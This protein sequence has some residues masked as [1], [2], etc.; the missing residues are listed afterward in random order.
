[1]VDGLRAAALGAYGNTIVPTPHCDRLAGQ[2]ATV[3]WLLAD[4]CQ[5]DR[6]YRSLWQRVHAARPEV[7]EGLRPLPDLLGQSGV[8]QVLVTD[9]PWLAQHAE[10]ME[11]DALHLIENSVDAAAV[12]IETTALG[13]LFAQAIS[14]WVAWQ[15][16]MDDPT[17]NASSSAHQRLLWV[18]AQG[19]FGPWDAP[20]SLRAELL[21][22]EDPPPAEFVWPEKNLAVDEPDLL[23]A[24]RT[25]YAA[26][27]SVFDQCLGAL[28]AALE[29]ARPGQ[30]T[31]VT[32]LGSRGYT[33]G[34]HGWTGTQVEAHYGEQL[35][36]PWLTYFPGRGEPLPRLGDL[37]QPADVGA[38]LL[39]WFGVEAGLPLTDGATALPVLLGQ[40]VGGRQFAYSCGKDTEQLLRTPA[41]LLRSCPTATQVELFA[42]PDDRWEF[43]EV[44]DRC[45]QIV[46][47]MQA[48][49]AQLRQQSLAGEPLSLGPLGP[50]LTSAMR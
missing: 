45:P 49:F 26:Q 40:P 37:W 47:Q 48:L 31:M 6:I 19:F 4:S 10:T 23:L 2:G 29:S 24:Q 11:W 27:V 22:E 38:T 13:K 21:D 34:E 17:G 30:E 41:W 16:E 28:L 18:H 43:N 25:A 14:R 44:A 32:V 42:K 8:E 33:L 36:V 50:E 1:V 15:E 3:E 5:L 7:P 12:D 9:E 35:H 39:D 20:S 46:E